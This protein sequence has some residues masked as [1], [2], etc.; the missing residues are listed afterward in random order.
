MDIILYYR[1]F[2]EVKFMNEF[3]E[4]WLC[5]KSISFFIKYFLKLLG[6]T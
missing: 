5:C 1:N 2:F 3:I 6:F 4:L